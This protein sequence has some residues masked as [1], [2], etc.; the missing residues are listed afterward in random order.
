MMIK[1][2]ISSALFLSLIGSQVLFAQQKRSLTHADY[3]GWESLSS[4]KISKNGEW[5]GYQVSPQDGDSRVEIFSFKNP[6]PLGI[7][8]R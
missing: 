4:E 7:V 6:D 1:K 8:I 2:F 3:D 5:V